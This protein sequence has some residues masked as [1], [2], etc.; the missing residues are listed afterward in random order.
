MNG[1]EKGGEFLRRPIASREEA[2]LR[3]RSA[4]ASIVSLFDIEGDDNIPAK[5]KLRALRT[6]AEWCRVIQRGIVSN[7]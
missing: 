4:V 6:S 1:K 7:L 5:G 3:S 2:Y